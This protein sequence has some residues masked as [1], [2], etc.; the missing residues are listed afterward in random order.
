[1]RKRAPRAL[2]VA[3]AVLA[4]GTA[5]ALAATRDFDHP[6]SHDTS[7]QFGFGSVQRQD[8]P[9]D[10]SYDSAEPDD[11]DGRSSSNFFD[12]DYR[13]FGFPSELTPLARYAAGPNTG[14][15]Q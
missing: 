3:L 12:E 6:A 9:N 1:M 4:P 7:Q 10:P 8:T 2:A 15:P 14:K 5:V 13:L 11:P